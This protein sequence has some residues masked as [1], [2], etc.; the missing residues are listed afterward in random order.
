M[1]NDPI[2]VVKIQKF[3]FRGRDV[4]V[5]ML[6]REKIQVPMPLVEGLK[7]IDT[8]KK[9]RGADIKVISPALAD[10]L[11]MGDNTFWGQ[12]P[13]QSGRFWIEFGRF[14]FPTDLW[15]IHEQKNK[16]FGETVEFAVHKGKPPLKFKVP[17]RFQGAGT[18]NTVL[19]V[20][21]LR[22]GD[23]NTEHILLNL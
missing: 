11:L 10:Y 14:G 15:I 8:I 23:L 12:V 19:V 6:G 4:F 7:T 2:G 20:R 1:G 9:E 16:P 18:E 13:E 21:G 22:S 3:D 5:G 17:Q